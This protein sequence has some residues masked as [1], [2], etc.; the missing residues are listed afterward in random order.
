M[1][2]YNPELV[3]WLNGASGQQQALDSVPL[4]DRAQR[5]AVH[6]LRRFRRLRRR[7]GRCV[8]ERR[9][10]RP[11]QHPLRHGPQGRGGRL[12]VGE[13]GL[14]GWLGRRRPTSQCDRSRP[15]R[16]RFRGG[17]RDADA[18]SHRDL[19]AHPGPDRYG[20]DA[21]GSA[22][23][24]SEA[25]FPAAQSAQAVV[26]ARSDFFADALAGGP[27]AAHSGGPLLITP[28]ASLSSTLDP[29]VLA[30]I[31]RVLV[32]GGTVFILG[33]DLA[34]SSNVD[35]TLEGLGYQVIREAGADEYGTAI[36][37][38]AADGQPDAHLRGHRAHASKT[39]SRRSRPPLRPAERSC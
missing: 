4:F 37:H 34:I 35:S 28:G 9:L 23:R 7:R 19:H 18:H 3:Q 10:Y 16:R 12:R 36:Q 31:Q 20:Q 25:E 30:E 24:D 33:G 1:T 2:F 17:P 39:L 5:G 27:L 26:L 15:D 29:R 8:L 21:I 22:I 6:R 32:P 38:R 13:R 14:P 11:R